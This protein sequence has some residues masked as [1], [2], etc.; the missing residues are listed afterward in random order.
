MLYLELFFRGG[1]PSLKTPVVSV[2]VVLAPCWFLWGKCVQAGVISSLLVLY[3]SCVNCSDGFG[4]DKVF[5]PEYLCQIALNIQRLGVNSF[6]LV[7][8]QKLVDSQGKGTQIHL[9][10]SLKTTYF[11][12]YYQQ[13]GVNSKLLKHTFFNQFS[14]FLSI[15]EK[16]DVNSS[17]KMQKVA[18]C[19]KP[20]QNYFG[21]LWGA[22]ALTLGNVIDQ[23][24]NIE[25]I[26]LIIALE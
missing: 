14:S 8:T 26:G 2:V 16:Q 11:Y 18:K 7:D 5:L 4:W 25:K 10:S 3:K 24:Q 23:T 15:K 19:I 22:Q 17:K 20:I 6:K 13:S 1:L 9:L 21:Q 12:Y